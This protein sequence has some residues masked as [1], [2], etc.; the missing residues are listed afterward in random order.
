M[1]GNRS[2]VRSQHL[3]V[4]L[5]EIV[6]LQCNSDGIKSA[7]TQ[8]LSN[9]DTI[10]FTVSVYAFVAYIIYSTYLVNTH[11][12][13]RDAYNIYTHYW[14]YFRTKDIINYKMAAW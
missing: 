4:T 1:Y 11:K 9:G 7:M 14:H 5:N 3:N 8:W 2:I 6:V 12:V 13:L 10:D